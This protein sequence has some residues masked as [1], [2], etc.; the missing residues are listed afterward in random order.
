[1]ID[2]VLTSLV[3]GAV[4][5]A[6]CAS[7]S[8]AQEQLEIGAT[9]GYYSP[10]GSFQPVQLYSTDLPRS[11]NSLSGTAFGGDLR[12]WFAPRVGLELAGSTIASSV[13]GGST[14]NGVRPSVPAR[15]TEGT[16]E[17][18]FRVTGDATRT[19]VWIGAGTAAIWHGGVAYRD[20]ENAMSLG[21]VIGLGSAF[22]IRGGLNANI[23]VSTLIYILDIHG[24]TLSDTA[25]EE[26]GTQ[27]DMMLRTGVSYSW[28]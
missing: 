19:R 17:L 13:G 5:V 11:P 16:A 21:S 3:A 14:P 18:L 10:M 7:R 8:A 9:V 12:L 25:V 27:S 15:V 2:R 20:F 4:L 26:R 24:S 1:V 22:R 28:P 23:G 6:A